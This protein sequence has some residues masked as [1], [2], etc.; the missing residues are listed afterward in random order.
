MSSTRRV[1]MTALAASL[2]LTALVAPNAGAAARHPAQPAARTVNAVDTSKLQVSYQ[3]KL[4][5]AAQA[6]S[7]RASRE[8]QHRSFV[9]V[10]DPSSAAKGLAHAFDTH[11]AADAYGATIKAANRANAGASS[12][13][14]ASRPAGAITPM[15]LPSGCPDAKNLSRM[16]DYTSCGGSQFDFLLTE[17]DASFTNVGWQNRGSSIVVGWT[18][19]GCTIL[20]RLWAS[21]NYT[22][23]EADFYGGTSAT[24]YA[25]TSA[26][27]NNAESGKSTCS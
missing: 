12:T 18:T 9:I 4:L 22:F 7:L 11:A 10:Y 3:G 25:F 19:S 5:T 24:Y 20:V 17:N 14:S 26:I 13:Q 15:S 16:Y 8:R 23:T 21:P 1:L 6:D 27:N 2:G